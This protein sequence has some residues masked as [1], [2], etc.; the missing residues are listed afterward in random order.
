VLVA[1][2]LVL[3]DGGGPPASWG[4]GTLVLLGALALAALA[5][6]PVELSR[7][8]LA[9]IGALAGLLAW[10]LASLAW[11]ASVPLT[12]LEPQRTLVYLAGLTAL[13]AIV[14]RRQLPAL[15]AG[16]LL[17]CVAA[18]VWNLVSRPF[19]GDD[20][21]AGAGPVGYANA[22]ALLAVIGLLLAAGLAARSDYRRLV[23]TGLCAL[24][25]GAV[26]VL[27]ESRG[28]WVALLAGVA[29]AGA[30]RLPRPGVA[31]ALAVAG[32]LATAFATALAASA[33]RRAYWEATLDGWLAAPVL[34]SGAGS[35]ERV[36]LGRRETL[37]PAR[38]AHSLYLETLAE[39]GPVGLLLLCAALVPPLAAA[40]RARRRPL[41]PAATSAYAAL[42]VHLA[43]DWG[44]ELAGVTLAGLACGAAAL[45]A[46]RED[47]IAAPPRVAALAA[48]AAIPPVVFLLA[49]NV[50]AAR[51]EDA[52]R[53]GDA[54]A[55]LRETG[56]ASWL[57][58]WAAGPRRLRAEASALLGDPAAARRSLRAALARDS[59]DP[60]A[61]RAALRLFTGEERRRAAARLR[62]V[63][64]LAAP[65][66]S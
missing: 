45:V 27:A 19:A 5:L 6:G 44:W 22:L 26:L 51:A 62:L 36:W 7:L 3:A 56:R 35:W 16:V 4:W 43:V 24:P 25:L 12:A 53:A 17:V 42:V 57:Q 28:A 60:D 15:L 49:G 8:D 55:A 9:A 65:P 34:G 10:Q 46:A 54:G 30:L 14:R 29:V 13:L 32:G 31:V 23:A 58:P 52:L 40:V 66:R 48:A 64:P 41:V 47:A 39:L 11:T 18:C 38:D 37:L 21:G 61:L 20:T 59:D 1:G 50:V 2:G 33:E 63:D